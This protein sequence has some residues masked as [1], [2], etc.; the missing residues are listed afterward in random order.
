MY[1]YMLYN[2]HVHEHLP[3]HDMCIEFCDPVGQLLEKKAWKVSL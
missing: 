3:A 1:M 2:V